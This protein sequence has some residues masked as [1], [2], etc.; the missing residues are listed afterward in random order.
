MSM[1]RWDAMIH[2][3]SRGRDEDTLLDSAESRPDSER[4]IDDQVT[5]VISRGGG[6][7][8]IGG[9]CMRLILQH[10]LPVL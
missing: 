5:R 1:T 2:T 8:V 7:H 9:S 10:R 4:L 3:P 6:D